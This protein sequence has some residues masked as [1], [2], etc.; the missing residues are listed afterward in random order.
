MRCL[1]R[2]LHVVVQFHI[3]MLVT[4]LWLATSTMIG[5]IRLMVI[6][7]IMVQIMSISVAIS[8]TN[9]VMF[10]NVVLKAFL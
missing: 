6:V 9:R 4:L 5:S 2:A 8:I 7:L 1:L 10:I 3:V